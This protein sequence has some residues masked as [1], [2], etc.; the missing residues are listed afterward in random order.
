MAAFVMLPQPQET[1]WMAQSSALYPK[2]DWSQIMLY[3]AIQAVLSLLI[4]K[5]TFDHCSIITGHFLIIF[6]ISVCWTL[7]TSPYPTFV[8]W[9]QPQETVWMAQSSVLYP[10]IEWSQIML[11]KVLLNRYWPDMSEWPE[12]QPPGPET[13]GRGPWRLATHSYQVNNLFIIPLCYVTILSASS[14]W[15]HDNYVKN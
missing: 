9:P 13:T 3:K 11:Y 1:V 12:V 4:R 2:I 6:E 15:R 8:M 5:H 10:K 7:G 14:A